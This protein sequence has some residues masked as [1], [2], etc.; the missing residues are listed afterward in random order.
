MCTTLCE[1]FSFDHLKNS[2]LTYFVT[3][4]LLEFFFVYHLEEWKCKEKCRKSSAHVSVTQFAQSRPLLSITPTLRKCLS[5]NSN[6]EARC[7]A[8]MDVMQFE[9]MMKWD[10]NWKVTNKKILFDCDRI[11]SAHNRYP[12]YVVVTS[13]IFNLKL[14]HSASQFSNLQILLFDIQLIILLR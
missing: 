2:L 5:I 8:L 9:G 11:F 7:S 12:S 13:E 1:N 14:T 10:D 3:L 6:H 4:L